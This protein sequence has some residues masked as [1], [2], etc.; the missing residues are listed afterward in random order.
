MQTGKAIT[1]VKHPSPMPRFWRAD[2]CP[3]PLS[4][5]AEWAGRT[6]RSELSSELNDILQNWGIWQSQEHLHLQAGF[7]P[8]R[9]QPVHD[10]ILVGLT[11]KCF[12]SVA[13]CC[14]QSEKY[15]TWKPICGEVSEARFCSI[16][17]NWRWVVGRLCLR[18]HVYR[19][20]V[21]H[22]CCEDWMESFT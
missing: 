18:L 15:C 1:L 11:S 17:Y 2:T 8:P 21:P 22:H 16:T 3:T 20:D 5:G 19:I 9:E 10:E 4:G 12:R 13:E 14:M 7:Y 6:P